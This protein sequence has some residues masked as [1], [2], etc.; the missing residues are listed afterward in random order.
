MGGNFC[1]RLGFESGTQQGIGGAQI[2]AAEFHPAHAVDD[3]RVLRRKA[4]RLLDQGAGFHQLHVAVGQ[5]VAQSVHRL[6]VIGVLGKQFAQNLLHRDEV[7]ELVGR[8]G[9]LIGQLRILGKT[10]HGLGQQ[11]VGTGFVFAGAQQLDLRA[12]FGARFFFALVGHGAHQFLR[13]I[14][15]ALGQ[16]H[17]YPP[18]A[19][20]ALVFGVGQAVQVGVGQHVVFVVFGQDRQ[21]EIGLRCDPATGYGVLACRVGLFENLS[22]ARQC[23]SRGFD[24]FF[25]EG[26]GAAYQPGFSRCWPQGGQRLR[27][28]VGLFDTRQFH[29][30]AHIGQA[31]IHRTRGFDEFIQ[32]LV[33]WGFFYLHQVQRQRGD[34]PVMGFDPRTVEGGL[35]CRCRVRGHELGGTNSRPHMGGELAARQLGRQRRLHHGCHALFVGNPC[36]V[37]RH[38]G[39]RCTAFGRRV[40][41][42]V[43]AQGFNGFIQPI[44]AH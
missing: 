16:Q 10:H 31:A 18:L 17:L 37:A 39:D 19:D 32:Y 26:D 13:R 1:V 7:F 6:V 42:Q 28:G 2:A 25:L 30:T 38:V 29:Q 4:E 34:L 14:Q 35:E 12:D 36:E 27:F 23:G 22:A 41:R 5:R 33:S 24:V 43:G 15:L 40:G 20:A 8:H 9:R 11:A 3:V 44:Q 21:Q